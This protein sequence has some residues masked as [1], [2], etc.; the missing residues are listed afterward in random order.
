MDCEISQ[1]AWGRIVR[2]VIITKDP[3]DVSKDVGPPKSG[4]V[5]VEN[6]ILLY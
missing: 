6:E 5:G 3:G 2:V 1:L 4:L